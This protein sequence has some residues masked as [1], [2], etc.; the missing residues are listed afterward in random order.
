LSEISHLSAHLFLFLDSSSSS[1]E[2][3]IRQCSVTSS[4]LYPNNLMSTLFSKAL[5]LRVI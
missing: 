1:M 4:F 2:L 3:I 5:S